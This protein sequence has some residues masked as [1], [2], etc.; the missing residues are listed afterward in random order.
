MTTGKT[1]VFKPWAWAVFILAVLVAG[2]CAGHDKHVEPRKLVTTTDRPGSINIDCGIYENYID[3]Q[4]GSHYKSDSDFVTT[5]E[6]KLVYVKDMDPHPQL[7]RMLNTLRSFPK[8]EK[9]CYTLKPEQGKGHHYMFRVFFFYGNYDGLRN[10]PTFEVYL[11]VNH[12]KTVVLQN[13]YWECYEI[14]QF[15]WTDTI[16]LCLANIGSGIP[17]ISGLELRL[18]YDSIYQI[19]SRVL[20]RLDGS[21]VIYNDRAS[22]YVMR[23]R[24]IFC[25]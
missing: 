19:K 24:A 14:I 7:G 8:G 1:L 16:D 15:L 12:W 3:Y 22:R 18:L 11:G 2:L 23:T 10:P 20:D 9:N 17:I 6:N 13:G 25:F 21:D 4:S 5:G